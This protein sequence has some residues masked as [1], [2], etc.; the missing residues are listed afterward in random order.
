MEPPEHALYE[1]VL[2][3]IP[4]GR[5]DIGTSQ[6]VEIPVTFVACGRFEL[7]AEVVIPEIRSRVGQARL[8]AVVL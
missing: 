5:L 8:K 7:S 1:G 2:S 6:E 3:D 4:I